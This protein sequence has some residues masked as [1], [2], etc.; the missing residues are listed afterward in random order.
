MGL[1]WVQGNCRN[2]AWAGDLWSMQN[3]LEKSLKEWEKYWEKN[4]E[5]RTTHMFPETTHMFPKTKR[6]KGGKIE[7]KDRQRRSA[8]ESSKSP[9]RTTNKTNPAKTRIEVKRKEKRRK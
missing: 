3:K 9:P 2:M 8:S 1:A 6:T 7:K 5:E 4:A